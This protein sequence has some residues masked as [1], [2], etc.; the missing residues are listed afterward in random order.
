M[1][2]RNAAALAFIGTLLMAVLLVWNLI[3]VIVNIVRGLAP[4]MNVLPALLYAFGA[5]TVAIFFYVFQKR[6]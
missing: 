2:P 3:F 5:C 4:A 1:T 6:Y